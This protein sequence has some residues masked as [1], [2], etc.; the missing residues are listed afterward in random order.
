MIPPE[1]V[2]LDEAQAHLNLSPA[3]DGS[4][5]AQDAD[6]QMKLDAATEFVCAYIADRT[7]T[8]DEWVATIEAWTPTTAPQVVRLAVLETTADFYRFRGDDADG[9]RQREPGFLPAAARSLLVRY[10]D[11]VLA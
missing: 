2:T 6:L 3:P 9:D 8:D 7:P 5:S 4:P 10:R 11:P 1:I